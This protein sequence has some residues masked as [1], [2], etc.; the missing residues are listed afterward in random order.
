MNQLL[1]CVAIAC[2]CLRLSNPADA[3]ASHT[4]PWLVAL[5]A[6]A[7]DVVRGPIV[8]VARD[9]RI[10]ENGKGADGMERPLGLVDDTLTVRI[11]ETL[12]GKQADVFEL[13]R[14]TAVADMRDMQCCDAGTQPDAAAS[15]PKQP[16]EQEKNDDGQQGNSDLPKAEPLIL[17]VQTNSRDGLVR[18]EVLVTPGTDFR[19]SSSLKREKWTLHGCAENMVDGA[20]AIRYSIER[21]NDDGPTVV[22]RR[23]KIDDLDDFAW[24]G[25][26]GGSS[27]TRSWLR[28]G[29]DPVPVLNRILA[30]RDKSFG[31]AAHYLTEL[32]PAAQSAAVPQLIDALNDGIEQT[33]RPAY[34]SLRA[35][36][37]QALGK[38]GP[39]AK[40][41]VPALVQRIEDE[42]AYVRVSAATALW[43]ITRHAAAVPALIAELKNEDRHVRS[44]AVGDLGDIADSRNSSVVI[45][46]LISTLTNDGH[47]NV[48]QRAAYALATT[49]GLARSEVPALKTALED[50]DDE[51]R[52]AASYAIDVIMG[53]QQDSNAAPPEHQEDSAFPARP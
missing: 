42:N 47:A 20:V 4:Y 5:V 29:I 46:A 14:S 15:A 19:V 13:V 34:D 32:E 16:Q 1:K 3:Q 7:E 8:D 23:F 38:F 45:P 2:V 35:A 43:R 50:K 48:R 10:P 25:I 39:A 27:M 22:N 36:A 49:R 6:D 51:V 52:R 40:A 9:V 37:A 18:L 26:I 53:R 12:R 17:E 28:R 21:A 44:R 24:V 31:G 11:D 33:N 41:A 30:R